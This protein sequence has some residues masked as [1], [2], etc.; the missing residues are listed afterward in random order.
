MRKL[1]ERMGVYKLRLNVHNEV[2]GTT[3]IKD[4]WTTVDLNPDGP[5][6][7]EIAKKE[8][9]DVLCTPANF[10][11]IR[12]IKYHSKEILSTCDSI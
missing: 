6:G 9:G 4:I 10:N 11:A 5:E 1:I 3:F 12:D 2:V 7:I 8:G